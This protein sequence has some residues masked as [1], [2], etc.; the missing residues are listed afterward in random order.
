MK[1][2]NLTKLDLQGIEQLSRAQ[3]KQIKG[4]DYGGGGWYLCTCYTCDTT[5]GQFFASD[6]SHPVESCQAFY[7]SADRAMCNPYN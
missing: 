1:K 4:G 6:I 7:P 5:D 2:A 3:L